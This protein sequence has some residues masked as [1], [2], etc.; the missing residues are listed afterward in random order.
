[1]RSRKREAL[2]GYMEQP[3]ETTRQWVTERVYAHTYG[4]SEQTLR[5]WRHKDLK[6][7]RM[8]AEPGKPQYR[9]FGRSIRYRL[10]DLQVGT[11]A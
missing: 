4:L 8:E 3:H 10:D 11:A 5:N 1:M 9:R 7:G 6:S 2:S